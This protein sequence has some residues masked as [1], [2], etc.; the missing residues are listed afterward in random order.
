VAARSTSAAPGH[1][2]Q[3]DK[4]VDGGVKANN[5]SPDALTKIHDYSKK[6]RKKQKCKLSCFVSL[7]CGRFDKERMDKDN[8]NLRQHIQ[9]FT[10]RHPVKGFIKLKQAFCEL[11]GMLVAEV[12]IKC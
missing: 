9:N 5:P 2:T 7:G 6:I 1:F 4:F 11:L 10:W 12:C 3:Y 8:L